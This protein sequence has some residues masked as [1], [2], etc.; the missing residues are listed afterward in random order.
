MTRITK[1]ELQRKY[2]E[3]LKIK[4]EKINDLS[5]KVQY[6]EQKLS[7]QEEKLNDQV[8]FNWLS[9]NKPFIERYLKEYL[10]TYLSINCTTGYGGDISVELLLDNITISESNDTITMDSNPLEE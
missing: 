3:L 10:P 4:D 6:L 1:D 2:L 9:L 7:E 5:F 8:Y